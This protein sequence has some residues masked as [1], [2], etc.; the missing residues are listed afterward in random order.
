MIFFTIAVGI[1]A[2]SLLVLLF[3]FVWIHSGALC[4]DHAE[5][6][7]V[8][9]YKC[10]RNNIPPLLLERLKV[11]KRLHD[12]MNFKKVILTGGKVGNAVLSEAEIMK[13]YLTKQGIQEDK[14]EL[15][16]EARDTIENLINCKNIMQ[17]QGF[18]SCVVVSNSFHIRRIQ[19]IAKRVG[20]E[21]TCAGERSWFTPFTQI[22]NTLNEIK[23]FGCTLK[24]LRKYKQSNL[25]NGGIS[26]E[27]R[28]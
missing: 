26:R 11:A 5:V 27:T 2:L 4:S 9:G 14:V 13:A 21:V 7:I 19:Y 28:S 6:L 18:Q 3:F 1:S 8:L 25:V 15:D 24:L 22:M 12:A 10:D 23:A 17:L 20:L 16:I